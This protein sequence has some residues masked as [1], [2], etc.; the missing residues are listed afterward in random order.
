[1]ETQCSRRRRRRIETDYQHLQPS[2]RCD[3]AALYCAVL[4]CDVLH[5][6]I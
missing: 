3:Y 1:M 2:S 4:H 5:K 6:F